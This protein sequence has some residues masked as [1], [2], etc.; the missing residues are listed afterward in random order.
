MDGKVPVA[1]LAFIVF[2]VPV[3]V[4]LVRIALVADLKQV[5]SEK[6]PVG[7]GDTTSY[8][9]LTGLAGAVMVMALYWAVANLAL[10]TAF[11]GTGVGELIGSFWL[12]FLIG[13]ALFLPYAFNQLKS[14]FT[15]AGVGAATVKAAADMQVAALAAPVAPG[16]ETLMIVN[17]S[18]TIGDAEFNAAVAAISR[19]VKEHFGPVWGYSAQLVASRL[20]L[21]GRKVN[22]DGVTHAIVYVGDKTDDPRGGVLKA[23]GYHSQTH[24]QLA[25]AF[26]YLDVCKAAGEAWTCTLSHEILE[27]LADRTA[28]MTMNGPVPA[29]VTDQGDT[30]LYA[31]EVCDPTQG[32]HYVIDGVT[33]ANFVTRAYFD[34]RATGVATNHLQ[35][36]L[37]PFGV[38]PGGYIQYEGSARVDVLNGPA[39]DAARL[40]ARTILGEHR[41]N[42]RRSAARGATPSQAPP[43]PAARKPRGLTSL[44][45]RSGRKV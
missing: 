8:S 5:L 31:M 21:N 44:L 29:G 42:A 37:T 30:V 39:V 13:G 9:R 24:G 45:R 11:F 34:A 26:V 1:W 4:A 36:P 10:Y 43:T 27:L 14:A 20:D 38:R 2:N 23:S 25:Y 22:V 12:L 7:E 35:L 18:K 3:V 15:M 16:T 32:D 6:G 40:A 41:R 28:G 33:V 17:V 19:Q